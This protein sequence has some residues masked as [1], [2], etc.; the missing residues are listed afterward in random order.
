MNQDTNREDR[1]TPLPPEEGIER[2]RAGAIKLGWIKAGCLVCG[3]R[4]DPY[5][6]LP[7]PCG[8][9]EL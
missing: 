7:C 5:G 8:Q 2:A 9:P 4:S 3:A 1:V 6:N